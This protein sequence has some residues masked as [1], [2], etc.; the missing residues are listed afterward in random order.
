M[1]KN[2]K[3]LARFAVLSVLSAAHRLAPF[4]VHPQ[5]AFL[6]DSALNLHGHAG[7]ETQR[8]PHLLGLVTPAPDPTAATS[9]VEFE[10]P[11]CGFQVAF[12]YS[13]LTKIRTR[14]RAADS[15]HVTARRAN[16]VLV[17]VNS[18]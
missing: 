9:N 7:W 13:G 12:S 17:F 16:A 8:Q 15:T 18:L 10:N 1:N 5:N 3:A 14:R 11:A 4:F 2:A 6:N